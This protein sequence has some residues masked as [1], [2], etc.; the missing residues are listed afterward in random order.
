MG[1]CAVGLEAPC[2]V[3]EKVTFSARSNGR[4]FPYKETERYRRRRTSLSPPTNSVCR[5]YST[6]RMRSTL[7]DSA[8]VRAEQPNWTLCGASRVPGTAP[9]GSRRFRRLAKPRHPTQADRAMPVEPCVKTCGD[10]LDG[11]DL[12]LPD[13]P[14][15]LR[16]PALRDHASAKAPSPSPGRESGPRETATV[17]A[18]V[19]A[20]GI[21]VV[22]VGK[23]RRLG[24]D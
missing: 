16:G 22:G 3:V 10:G 7:A 17:R 4:S 13:R 21:A 12:G 9:L 24:E 19:M 8:G 20:R 11:H 18:A 14:S 15:E 2:A 1:T 6:Y 5:R 23:H